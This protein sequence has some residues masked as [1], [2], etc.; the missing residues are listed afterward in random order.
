MNDLRTPPR[1]VDDLMLAARHSW[2]V[3]YDNVSKISAE[4]SD[5]MCRLSSGGALTKRALYT[6]GDEFSIRACR[7]QVWNG[8]P[9][10]LASR[11]D[12]IDRIILITT[13]AIVPANRKTEGEFWADFK[14]AHPY[15]LG[16]LLDGVSAALRNAHKIKI[17]EK[18][19][20]IDFVRHA[21]AG[22]QALGFEPGE[23]T[24][25]YLTN[26]ELAG[27]GAL[28]DNPV[29]QGVILLADR[30]QP[31]L[32]TAGELFTKLHTLV[33]SHSAAD[34]FRRFPKEPSQLSSMLRRL[35]RVLRFRRIEVSFDQRL[36]RNSHRGISIRKLKV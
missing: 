32:G 12:L 24:Q 4:V 27:S 9:D 7:P 17:E 28:E 31:F 11:P 34:L 20:L 16:A 8:I 30:G 6:D 25:A 5:G 29:A 23:F 1:D 10:D 26:R 22:C 13:P 2:I 15:I 18:P 14:E 33:A 36:N 35:V 21:E 3:S 19:R